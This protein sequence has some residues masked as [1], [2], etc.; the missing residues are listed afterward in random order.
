LVELRRSDTVVEAVQG[1]PPHREPAP[2][3]DTNGKGR[4]ANEDRERVSQTGQRGAVT[5]VV[6]ALDLRDKVSRRWSS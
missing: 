3:V 6:G 5:L 2:I 1:A 4:I